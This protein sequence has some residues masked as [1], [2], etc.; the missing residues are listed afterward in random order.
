MLSFGQN[1]SIHFVINSTS[2]SF[3]RAFSISFSFSAYSQAHS[4]GTEQY[5]KW[6]QFIIN[7]SRQTL[8]LYYLPL[9]CSNCL[10]FSLS[11]VCF[12]LF[13]SFLC[14]CGCSFWWEHWSALWSALVRTVARTVELGCPANLA[15]LH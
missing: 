9:V 4:F 8:A 15:N 7:T 5:D 2:S 10:S 14:C 6:R 11:S 12:Y 3:G 1:L 13:M